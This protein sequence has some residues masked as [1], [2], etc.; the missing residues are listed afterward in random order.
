MITQQERFALCQKAFVGKLA[1]L[2]GFLLYTQIPA[3]LLLLLGPTNP[4]AVTLFF[5]LIGV[6]VAI[7]FIFEALIIG[8]VKMSLKYFWT[9]PIW[10]FMHLYFGLF[11]LTHNEVEYHGKVFR[12]SDR[13]TLKELKTPEAEAPQTEWGPPETN[14]KSYRTP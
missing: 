5:S 12:F 6:R 14:P 8:S 1:I 10:D 11:A 13:F 7:S 3:T 9:I 2:L 4:V